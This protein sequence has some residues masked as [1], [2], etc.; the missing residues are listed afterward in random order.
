M[1]AYGPVK[2]QVVR[3]VLVLSNMPALE[4]K[5]AIFQAVDCVGC[6]VCDCVLIKHS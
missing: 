3:C 1:G 2:S 4:M 6:L 5:N